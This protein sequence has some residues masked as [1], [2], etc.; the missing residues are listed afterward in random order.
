MQ[1]DN[2]AAEE[3]L[4]FIVGPAV[5]AEA[6]AGDDLIAADHGVAAALKQVF[7]FLKIGVTVAAEPILKMAGFRLAFR[8]AEAESMILP[9]IIKQQSVAKTMSGRPLTGLIV[10]TS[11]PSFSV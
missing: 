10:S 2:F 4:Q 9:P 11:Q 1:A 8:V 7:G 3:F 6:V 5:G